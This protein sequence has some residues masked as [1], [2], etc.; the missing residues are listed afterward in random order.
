MKI[1]VLLVVNFALAFIPS[2]H[3]QNENIQKESTA[4][5]DSLL[6]LYHRAAAKADF[7]SYFGFFAEDAVFI[8]TDATERWE[9]RDFMAWAKPYFDKGTTWNFTALQRHIT[10]D[11]TGQIAWFDE[12]LDTRMKICRG[13]GVLVR[14]NNTWKIKQ[15][16]LSMTIP[17]EKSD[18][19]IKIKAPLEEEIIEFLYDKKRSEK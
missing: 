10:I 8:G 19:I 14:T 12:L 5:L 18:S 9:K 6:N 1:I 15:Y 2:A 16:V 17:N 3:S 7:E 13:S 4:T 11:N